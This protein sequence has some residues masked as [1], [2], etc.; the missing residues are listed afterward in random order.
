M[1]KFNLRSALEKNGAALDESQIKF[2]SA[3]E[4][5]LEERAKAQD[6]A[7]STSMQQALRSVLG[8]ETKDATGN[9]VTIAE[10]IRSIAES[11]EKVEKN[12]VRNLSNTEKFQLRKTIKKQHAEICD[13]IRSGKDLEINFSAKRSAAM[14]TADTAVSNDMGVDFPLNENFEFE[15]EIA[16]IRYPE[17]FILNVIS[18][19]QV[20]KVPQQI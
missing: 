11:V 16:K 15:S 9:V 3:F 14:Y 6:E 13:A 5:A 17:N 10:Q 7:Y 4:N 2:V 19:Q 8:A 1:E 12:N 18:N 20:A